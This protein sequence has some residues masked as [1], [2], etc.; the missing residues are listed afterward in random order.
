MTD[1][2]RLTVLGSGYLGITHAAS[3]ASLGFEVLGVDTDRRKV[4]QLNAG[5]LPIYEPGLEKLLRERLGAGP[6]EVHHLLSGG[7]GVR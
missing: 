7:G 5:E 4:D 1:G 2:L 6:G 3:M